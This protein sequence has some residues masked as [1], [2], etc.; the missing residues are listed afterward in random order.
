MDYSEAALQKVRE[1]RMLLDEVDDWVYEL[2]EPFIG[3]RVLEIGCGLGNFTRR[4]TN[5]ELYIGTDIS[6]ECINYIKDNFEGYTNIRAY[7]VNVADESVLGLSHYSIDTVFSLNVFEHIVD[8]RAAIKI[9]AQMLQPGGVA[10]LV[11]PAHN[12]LYGSM[13][14]PIGHYRR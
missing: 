6:T 4:L 11:V 5:R 12:L 13:D 8:D 1:D 7:A 10:I 9:I 2:I 14:K 3:Q